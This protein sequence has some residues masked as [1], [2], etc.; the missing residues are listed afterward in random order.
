MA[1]IIVLVFR[2]YELIIIARAV[3]SWIR[4]DT[5]HPV[6]QWIYRLTEPL[7]DPIRR[8]LPTGRTGFDFSPLLLLLALQL[9]ERLVVAMLFQF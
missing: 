7:L 1:S 5:Y 9:I 8:M 6:V 3:I 2:I 4:V